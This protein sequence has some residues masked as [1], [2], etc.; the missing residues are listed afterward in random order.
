MPPKR[1]PDP[2]DKPAGA[3]CTHD[4]T[5]YRTIKTSLKS[6]IKTPDIH[7]KI[8]ELVLRINP[9]VI[10]TY[11]FIR[12]YC[13]HLYHHQQPIPDLDSTF[14]SYCMLA[15]G[16]RD[17]R[18]RQP[19]QT[20]VVKEL[21]H[22]YETEFQ[23]IF[24]HT[25]FNLKLLTYPLSYIQQTMETCLTVNVKEHFC[26]RL[27]RF[28]NIFADKY[29][30]E[31]VGIEVEHTDE[32]IRSK[33][34]TI[35]KLKKAMMENKPDSSFSHS[36]CQIVLAKAAESLKITRSRLADVCHSHNNKGIKGINGTTSLCPEPHRI[37]GG[38]IAGHLQAY[39]VLPGYPCKWGWPFLGNSK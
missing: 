15:M 19:L 4:K 3:N 2:P 16:E 13:L 30:D 11:Q 35:W 20:G 28:I 17:A 24:N 31:M 26:K 7:Q 12:L 8:N 25:K 32:Y 34:E 6:I 22:F 10:D 21:N 1:K 39:T 33:R 29:Y 36:A 5:P 38:M 9:I 18:G 27:L 14:I 37:N 23:P